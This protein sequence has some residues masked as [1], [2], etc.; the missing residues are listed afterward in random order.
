MQL[1]KSCF[2]DTTYQHDLQIHLTN[3][4]EYILRR[5]VM[6]L[7]VFWVR[8]AWNVK[9][10][11][12][13]ESEGRKKVEIGGHLKVGQISDICSSVSLKSANPNQQA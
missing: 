11:I 2:L 9:V 3:V 10:D 5:V 13:K 8:L 6:E 4:V 7:C 12:W 1:K